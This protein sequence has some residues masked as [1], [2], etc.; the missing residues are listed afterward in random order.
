MFHGL[1][2]FPHLSFVLTQM[3][4]GQVTLLVDG[5]LLDIAYSLKIL[6]SRSA[7]KSKQLSIDLVQ[8]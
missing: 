8:S 6:L 2:F 1:H 7:V 5:Q 4:I 3:Q